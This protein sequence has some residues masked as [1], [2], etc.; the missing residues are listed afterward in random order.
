M[1]GI[2]ALD[3]ATNAGWAAWCEGWN[4]PRSSYF[5]LPSSG[6]DVGRFVNCFDNWLRKFLADNPITLVVHE[7][8]FVGKKTKQATAKKLFG[9]A[10]YAE[11]TPRALGINYW[12]EHMGNVRKH[13]LHT[14]PSIKRKGLS[15][16]EIA[17]QKKELRA[18]IKTAIKLRCGE[19]G[20]EVRNDDES[21]ALALLDY[22]AFVQRAAFN[23]PWDCRPATGPLFSAAARGNDAPTLL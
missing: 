15:K 18:N 6:E 17:K 23:V 13:F 5:T 4:A 3:L 19:K 22:E 9:L 14:I 21:D 10:A 7:M 2:L 8:P 11:G 12:S 20:W 16:A 1:V